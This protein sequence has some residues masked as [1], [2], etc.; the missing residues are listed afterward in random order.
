MGYTCRTSSPPPTLVHQDR[1]LCTSDWEDTHAACTLRCLAS[2]I[3]DHSP[4]F[5]DYAPVPAAH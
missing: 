3:S 2:L 4:L 1:V 5:L